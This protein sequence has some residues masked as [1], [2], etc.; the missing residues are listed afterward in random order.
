MA[1]SQILTLTPTINTNPNPIQ[2]FYAFFEHRSLIFSLAPKL[3]EHVWIK[4]SQLC[5]V[6]I[7]E[8]QYFFNKI[9]NFLQKFTVSISVH[10]MKLT[11]TSALT[12]HPA[13]EKTVEM[14]SCDTPDYVS[15]L[16]WPPNSPDL[17][18][19]DYAVWDKLQERI[20]RTRI[21]DVDHLVYK[22]LLE[23]WSRFN[24]TSPL[25][26][27]FSGKLVCA[28]VLRR[29]EDILNTFYNNWRM[30]TMLHCH[31]NLFFEVYNDLYVKFLQMF[32]HNVQMCAKFRFKKFPDVCALF[33]YYAVIFGGGRL[34]WTRGIYYCS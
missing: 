29:T 30:T 32:V 12:A 7:Y 28:C 23:E 25:L 26:Q 2:L 15:P 31:G 4:Y 11:L 33:D 1:L 13:R 3:P 18:P 20:Y 14:L 19:V 8:Y 16:Q 5:L 24:H 9:A 21:R 27:L 10:S 34:S 17:K 22:R 6:T